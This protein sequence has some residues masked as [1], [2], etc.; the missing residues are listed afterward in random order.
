MSN[1]PLLDALADYFKAENWPYL[2]LE[3]RPV[4]SLNY[5]GQHASWTCY[6]QARE[7]Q[8][9]VIFYSVCPV[10]TPVER[11]AALAEYLTR[12]NYGLIIGNFELD[13]E[14]GEIRYKTSLDVEGLT[15]GPVVLKN[16]INANVSTLDQY[17]PGLLTLLFADASPREM[18]DRVEG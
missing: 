1:T 10:S 17:L 2:Q 16:L 6:A 5:T 7:E 18:I 8:Q 13:F 3:D 15:L 14:D 9:Q 4:L 12:A 11:R